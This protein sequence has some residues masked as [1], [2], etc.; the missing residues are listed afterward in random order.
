MLS[1]IV[2]KKEL[3]NMDIF[4][5]Q[6]GFTLIELVIVIVLI[7]IL[8]ATAAPRFLN[9]SDDAR[10][11]ALQSMHGSIKEVIR[12]VD[13]LSAI[14]DRVTFDSDNNKL[15][16]TYASGMDLLLVN[17]DSSYYLSR[18]EICRTIGLVDETLNTNETLTSKDGRYE[19]YYASANGLTRHNNNGNHGNGGNDASDYAL[20]ITDVNNRN[21]CLVFEGTDTGTIYTD[22]THCG[23]TD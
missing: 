3:K 14:S 1:W 10:L 13:A 9:L 20:A 7:G 15:S 5:R 22:G 2:T 8:A 18:S 4:K 11:A 21:Y 6:N 16:V 23:S 19:C 12:N 17:D